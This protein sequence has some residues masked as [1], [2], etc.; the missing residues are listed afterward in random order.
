MARATVGERERGKGGWGV[1][2]DSNPITM[3]R[4]RVAGRATRERKK[5]KKEKG[6]SRSQ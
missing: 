4:G 3:K 6:I 5:T 2:S 1:K